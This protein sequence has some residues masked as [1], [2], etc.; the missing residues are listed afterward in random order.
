[1][2]LNEAMRPRWEGVSAISDPFF[3]VAVLSKALQSRG[4]AVK[5]CR[6]SWQLDGAQ[7]ETVNYLLVDGTIL[8]PGNEIGDNAVCAAQAPMVDCKS[9]SRSQAEQMEE[10]IARYAL[11]DFRDFLEGEV[12]AAVSVLDA[13]HLLAQT[14]PS[15]GLPLRRTL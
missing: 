10:V 13:M 4:I 12:A 15:N 2:D 6:V 5:A 11:G 14:P 8:G 3:Q 1:M 7:F 9:W